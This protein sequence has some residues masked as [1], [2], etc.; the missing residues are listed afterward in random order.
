MNKLAQRLYQHAMSPDVKHRD[1]ARNVDTALMLQSPAE[2]ARLTNFLRTEPDNV[3]C[4]L[5]SFTVKEAG[6]NKTLSPTLIVDTP[7]D[8]FVLRIE[9]VLA[10]ETPRGLLAETVSLAY[11]AS[12]PAWIAEQ[13]ES[14]DTEA[15]MSIF[16]RADYDLPAPCVCSVSKHSS[17]QDHLKIV[18]CDHPQLRPKAS[19]TKTVPLSAKL[20]SDSEGRFLGVVRNGTSDVYMLKTPDAIDEDVERISVDSDSFETFRTAVQLAATQM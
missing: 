12:S 15:Y 9:N 4:G 6:S 5:T 14:P 11:L 18:L 13:L 17:S 16:P 8:K 7:L 20:I 10:A 1:L 3:R 19:A 2:Q